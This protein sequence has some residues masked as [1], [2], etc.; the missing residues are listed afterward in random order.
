MQTCKVISVIN[1]DN[2]IRERDVLENLNIDDVVDSFASLSSAL[3]KAP[4]R[5][6][7]EW[8]DCFRV[9]TDVQ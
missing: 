8:S 4:P 2:S 9:S 1:S 7:I 3:Y 6:I 5:V